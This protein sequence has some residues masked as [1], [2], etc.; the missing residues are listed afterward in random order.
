MSKKIVVTG[1]LGH[2]GSYLIRQFPLHFPKVEIR[3]IDNLSTQRYAALF[4][5]PDNVH[6]IFEEGDVRTVELAQHTQDADVLIHLAAM[7]DATRS[8][9]MQS[10]MEAVNFKSTQ[11]V[12]EACIQTATPLLYI[13]STSVYGSQALKVDENCPREVL[14]PQSPYAEIKLKEENFILK[15][16]KDFGLLAAI[17]RFGTIYGTSPGMRFHTAINKFCWQAVMELPLT[18]WETA[19]DQKRPYLHLD[20]ALRAIVFLIS[21]SLWDSRIYN[22]VSVNATVREVIHEIQAVIPSVQL[23]FVKH[24]IMNQLSY[25]VLCTHLAQAG[26]SPQ[27]HLKEGIRDT[28]NLLKNAHSKTR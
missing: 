4:N 11:K 8:F 25:E 9:E 19:Y 28:L 2:I 14:N 13:S 24:E 1:A 21:H 10:E 22:V 12:V 5:L 7:T 3:M 6:Y 26:F 27:M 17:C 15:N 16:C 23:K 18:V 20:D